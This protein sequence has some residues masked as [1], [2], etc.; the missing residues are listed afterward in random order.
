[1]T[2]SADEFDYIVVGAGSSGSVLANKLSADPDIRVLLLEAGGDDHDRWV[3][4]PLGMGRMLT[5]PNYVWPFSTQPEPELNGQQV[6][7]PRGRLLGGSS[8]VNGMLFVRGAPH[9]YDAWRDGNNP[10]WGYD[11]LLPY[12][13][14]IESFAEGDTTRGVEGP[15]Q[16]TKCVNRD[17][18]SSAFLS[19]CVEQGTFE[20]SDYNAGQFE[21]ASWLQYNIRQG[22]RCSAATAYLDPIKKRANLEIYT[23]T[24]ATRIEIE[25]RCARGVH[26]V[27]NGVPGYALASAEVLLSAGPIISPQL[28]ELSGIGNPEIVQAHGLELVHALPGVGEH[29]QD[30]LQNRITYETNQKVTVNDVVNNPLR[31]AMAG[32]QYMMFKTGMLATTVATVHAIMRSQPDVPH[33]DVKLQIMLTSGKDRYARSRKVG[34]DPFSGF[35]IGAFQLYP[36]SRGSVHI[37]SADPLIAP[38]IHANYLS[39]PRDV[40]VVVRGLKIAREIAQQPAL[41]PLIVREVRPGPDATDD[42]GLLSY[43]R[44][45]SQT[46][47]HPI[48]TCR[49]GRGEDDVVDHDLRVHGI[50][51]LRVI[52]SSIMPNMPTS[53]TN[54]PSIMIGAKG[55]DMVLAA[56][57]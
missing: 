34:L 14:E 24:Q 44:E 32:L 3:Q 46:S 53:N 40:D 39:D 8:S 11:E 55:A 19:A 57:N 20:N 15:V 33:P 10:G 16:I 36:H 51:R 28:L 2:R 35:N 18:L 43:A 12:F 13:K 9:K 45:T 6:F 4:M 23:H 7:W 30:H 41:A 49:M 31:G 1:M 37:E 22:Q 29:L 38:R 17:P 48:S 27:R 26:Y 47:W 52:D 42:A 54:A 25:D 56:R 5:D 21:G 50:E